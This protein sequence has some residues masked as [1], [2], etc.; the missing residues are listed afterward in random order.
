MQKN[1]YEIRLELLFLAKEVLLAK[2]NA[3]RELTVQEWHF[4]SQAALDEK[5]QPPPPPEI[6]GAVSSVQIIEEA[7]KLYQ[8]VMDSKSK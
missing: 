4:R 2:F 7:T 3:D 5:Q 8:F 1:G 6:A